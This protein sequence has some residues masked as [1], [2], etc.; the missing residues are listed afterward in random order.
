MMGRVTFRP[1]AAVPGIALVVGCRARPH[2]EV[3]AI[4]LL[5]A[6]CRLPNQTHSRTWARFP[7]FDDAERA[8]LA[9]ET[10]LFEHGHYN[11]AV[12]EA[13]DAGMLAIPEL[14]VWYEVV[15]G[16]DTMTPTVK[17]IEKPVELERTVCWGMG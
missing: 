9:N 8:V 2:P 4:F 14:E 3:G 16:A 6:V 10:D 5:T 12:I 11:L 7:T 17:R 13:Y 1:R 15:A